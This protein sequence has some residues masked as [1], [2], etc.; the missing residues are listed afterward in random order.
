MSRRG[1]ITL[2]Y[3][4]AVT[5]VLVTQQAGNQLLWPVAGTVPFALLIVV[6]AV[7]GN[8]PGRRLASCALALAAIGPVL[9]ATFTG[10]LGGWLAVA[11]FLAGAGVLTG[12]FTRAA[13]GTRRRFLR[14][15]LIGG[16]TLVILILILIGYSAR[17]ALRP[18]PP[19]CVDTCWGN[20]LGVYIMVA[21]EIEV[22]ALILVVAAFAAGWLAGLGALGLAIAEQVVWWGYGA[23]GTSPGH[24]VFMMLIYAGVLM[25]TNPWT[26]LLLSA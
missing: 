6:V 26:R 13:A 3:L 18:V 11:C 17:V 12:A 7:S 2:L 21:F 14:A 9:A 20:G 4:L 23:N 10:G 22:V 16:G 15:F 8:R 1:R 5:C 25:V 19:G 24:V